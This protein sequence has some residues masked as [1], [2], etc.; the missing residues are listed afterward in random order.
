MKFIILDDV[1]D[2]NT[3]LAMV[4]RDYGSDIDW[5]KPGDNP[6][7]EKILDLCKTW[8]FN[9]ES[10]VGYE[11]WCNAHNPTWHYDKDE[12]YYDEQQIY[13]FP[14]CSIVYYA[15]IG[16]DLEGGDFCT[17]DIRLAPKTNRLV[18]FAPGIYHN[19]YEFTGTRKA[20]SINPWSYIPKTHEGK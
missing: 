19:V 6:I 14:L 7:E 16:N 17:Q 4:N 2:E 5:W 10:M 15:E 8:Y 9:L 13:K 11:M 1:F 3:R 12:T 18:L 20:I